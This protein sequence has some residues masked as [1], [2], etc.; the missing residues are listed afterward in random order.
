MEGLVGTEGE[1]YL[2][3]IP[4]GKHMAELVYKG[5]KCEFNMII[6]E[7]EEM[8]IDLGEISCMAE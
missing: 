2:E 6:P 1:F 7:S 4:S 5:N 3:N 8:L